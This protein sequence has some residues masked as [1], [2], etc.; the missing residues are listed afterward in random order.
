MKQINL[1]TGL[2]FKRGD[3][4]D[5]GFIFHGYSLKKD[6]SYRTVWSSPIAFSKVKQSWAEQNKK[7][8]SSKLNHIRKLWHTAKARAKKQNIPFSVSLEHV[9]TIPSNVCPI[10]N[11]KLAWAVSG[12]GKQPNNPSLDKIIPE[13][14][15]VAGNVQWLSD[16]ANTMK[17]NASFKELHQFADWVKSTI[18][19]E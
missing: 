14:G 7:R 16:K 1:K 8:V 9:A 13:L 2:A 5:D 3:L 11:I 17:H 19:N 15:Y 4:R 6:G 18:P 10:L 12:K